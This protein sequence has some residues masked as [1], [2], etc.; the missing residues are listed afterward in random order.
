M[1]TV[2]HTHTHI[3]EVRS[4]SWTHIPNRREKEGPGVIHRETQKLRHPENELKKVD[5]VVSV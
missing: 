5:K 2:T 3:N 1:V 4:G